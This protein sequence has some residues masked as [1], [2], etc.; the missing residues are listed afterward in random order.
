[1]TD[2]LRKSVPEPVRGVCLALQQA[3]FQ[4]V[5]VGGAVRDALL[6]RRPGDWDVATSATPDQVIALFDKTFPTGM[7]HG[8]VTV[9]MGRGRKRMSIEVTSFRTEQ[10]YSDHRHPD[11]V[12]FGV[13]LE[14]DLARRDFV[15]NA[16]AYDPVA[17]ELIDPFAGQRDLLAKRVRAVGDAAERFAEDGLRVMRAVRFAATLGFALDQATEDAIPGALGS[18]AKVSIE[19]IREELLKLLGAP[20]PSIGLAISDRCGVLAQV[21]PELLPTFAIVPLSH[22]MRRIDAVTVGTANSRE[23]TAS[24]ATSVRLAA[25]LWPLGQRERV[26]GVLRRLKCSNA[27]CAHIATVTAAAVRYRE[28][29][30]AHAAARDPSL[31]RLL[32]QAGRVWAHDVTALWQAEAMALRQRPQGE[33]DGEGEGEHA[34]ADPMGRASRLDALSARASEILAAGDAVC[35]A[36]LDISGKELMAALAIKPGPHIGRL[37][38]KLLDYV[39]EDPTRNHKSALIA[40]AQQMLAQTREP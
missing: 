3:D 22:T 6:G 16:M 4:A 34:D 5:A 7:A 30:V 32:G 24:D 21:L 10:G 35:V 20:Q 25:L 37:L 40:A 26:D 2:L 38:A 33:S 29:E 12:T 23:H 15:I 31:R 1:M 18:L 19:R 17:D 8:T 39:L 27:D 28:I 9:R 11:H 36:D 14:E 13:S